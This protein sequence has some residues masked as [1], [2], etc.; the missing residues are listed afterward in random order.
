MTTQKIGVLFTDNITSERYHVLTESSIERDV[1]EHDRRADGEIYVFLYNW[2][3]I[4]DIDALW[5]H[6]DCQL[7]IWLSR[8]DFHL[9]KG[10]EWFSPYEQQKDNSVVKPYGIRLQNK[11]IFFPAY[12]EYVRAKHHNDNGD[13]YGRTRESHTWVLPVAQ[14]LYNTVD[15]IQRAIDMPFLWTPGST[16]MRVLREENRNKIILPFKPTPLWDTVQGRMVARPIWQHRTRDGKKGLTDEQKKK[17]YIIG[18]DKNS[19][20]LGACINLMLCNGK[21]IEVGSKE[22]SPFL[23]HGQVAMWEYKLEDVSQSA[24][25][26]YEL[27]CPLSVHDDW[28][29]TELLEFARSVGI[30]FS[31][32]RGMVWKGEMGRYMTEW[33]LRLYRGRQKI[34]DA[35]L[36]LDTIAATNAAMTVKKMYLDTIGRLCADY[37]DEYYHKDWNRFIIHKAITNQGYTIWKRVREHGLIPYSHVLVINDS[38]YILSDSDNTSIAYPDILAHTKELRGYTCIGVAPL[39]EEIISSFE[40][41]RPME[42]ENTIKRNMGVNK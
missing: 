2:M 13:T 33:A 40:T 27:Y 37:S 11:Y 26:G 22:F 1:L 34:Q 42:L 21:P 25:N 17:K 41:Q 12:G 30:K 18:Y 31:I 19:Q 14:E 15:Y 35:S 23:I 32:K 6:P 8:R 5:V 16:S 20:Y 36:G 39:N 28:A 4:K 3:C 9:I 7:S 24:F 10:L 29:S 38:F